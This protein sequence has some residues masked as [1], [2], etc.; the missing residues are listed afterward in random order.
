MENRLEQALEFANYKQTLNNQLHKSKIKAES[1]LIIAEGGGKFKINRELICFIDFLI[2]GEHTDAVLLDE[3]NSP[4][5]I[6]DL[7]AFLKKVKV[8]YFEVL[9][10]YL[11][12]SQLLKKSRNVKSI[13]DIKDL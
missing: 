7:P 11:Q 5:F 3:N 8:R 4:I 2:R 10:D 12:E 9:N 6:N 13:L 1:L